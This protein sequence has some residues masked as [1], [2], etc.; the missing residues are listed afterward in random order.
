MRAEL[1]LI[2]AGFAKLPTLTGNANKPII[3]NAGSTALTT[4]TGTLSLAG[5]FTLTGA[6]DTTVVQS[7]STT[8]T[9]PAV[10][11][12]LATLAG[13]ESLSSK[14]LVS[15]VLSGTATGTYT[16]AGT[17][18]ITAPAISSPVLSGTATGTYTMGGTGTY[19]SPTLNTGTVG[20]VAKT[21]LGI[22]SNSQ[23]TKA[24]WGF[25]YA[26]NGADAVNN[27]DLAVGGSMD[28]TGVYWIA[29][30]ALTKQSHVTWAVG[31]NAGALDTGVVGNNDYYMWT[32]AR[33][34]TGVTDSLFSLS[35]TAPTMPANYDFKR[36]I[37]WFK[38]VGGTIVAFHT[39]ETEGGGLEL[40][41]DV[42]TLDVNVANGLTTSRRTD[43]VKVPLNFSTIAHL[44]VAITD[45]SAIATTWVYCPDQTD[46]A[47]SQTVA[48]LSNS[49]NYPTSGLWSAQMKVRTSA[50]GLIAART[51]LST[52]DVYAVSTMG[53]TWARRN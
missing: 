32:I 27:L 13:T 19:T 2:A 48:P 41:W 5:N 30:A 12:T 53:F 40:N 50:A 51:T 34:D 3:V 8:L 16:L 10:S 21:P 22:P 35:S 37:G 7:A 25:T 38:R 39:Y 15:P 28:A 1:D 49:I 31:N 20:A 52:V 24:I 4:T 11:G 45:V 33:S 43:A 9:L 36:L 46:A 18:T 29:T 23:L 14:T 26:N 6:F 47:P 17:P 44:N 42:P